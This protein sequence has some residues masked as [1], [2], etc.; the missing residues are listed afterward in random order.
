MRALEKDSTWSGIVLHG[1]EEK[2]NY[3]R[4][5]RVLTHCDISRIN[6]NNRK[7]IANQSKGINFNDYENY[8]EYGSVAAISSPLQI[9]HCTIRDCNSVNGGG[10][11]LKNSGSAKV[12]FNKIGQN[13]AKLGGG[14]YVEDSNHPQIFANKIFSNSDELEDCSKTH[15]IKKLANKGA[16]IYVKDS[17]LL[18][19]SNKIPNSI[20]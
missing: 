2:E 20:I 8:L 9:I 13:S 14:I 17:L 16:G 11:Y 19:R 10:L 3:T 4:H 1:K 6:T 12:C 18:I 7:L 5:Q 15:K